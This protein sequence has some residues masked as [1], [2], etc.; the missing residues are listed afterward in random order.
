MLLRTFAFVAKTAKNTQ[1]I[2]LTFIIVIIIVIINLNLPTC[3]NSG[4]T[5]GL[6]QKIN[7][8][9]HCE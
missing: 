2:Y 5:S 3:Q 8:H 7:I 9:R 4:E 1:I 6:I